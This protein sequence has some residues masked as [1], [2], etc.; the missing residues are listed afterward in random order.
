M[1]GGIFSFS[2]MRNIKLTLEYDGTEFVGWQMQ[3]N[4]RSV[5][6]EL[7]K[8]LAQL[9]QESV[10]TI[11]AGRTDAGVH[12]RGQV[13]NFRTNTAMG[14]DE[15]KRGS[16]ALLPEDVVVLAVEEVP[17]DFH[18]RYGATSRS[19]SYQILRRPSAL[20]RH[21]AWHVGFQLDLSLLSMCAETLIG[22][23][24]F[25]SFSKNGSS[26]GDHRCRVTKARW[27]YDGDMLIFEITSNR[28]LYGM[29]RALVG[30]MVDVARG[31]RSQNDWK[32]LVATP[33]GSEPGMSAPARGLFL[34]SVT[35]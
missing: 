10:K 16:N 31:H 32:T 4:G 26:A 29:V 12:A 1:C 9:L 33:R 35:Y 7:E 3:P 19:Y 21:F 23:H 11:G 30:T 28:F 13:A 25:G 22:E 17:L 2:V 24:D 8:A 14:I 15:L 18:A 20:Q 6:G 27:V 34:D 5:Q